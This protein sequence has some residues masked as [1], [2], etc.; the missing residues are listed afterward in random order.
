M[1][2]NIEVEAKFKVNNIKKVID[3]L[4]ASG[5]KLNWVSTIEDYYYT[6]KHRDLWKIGDAL[7]VRIIK[8]KKGGILTYKP[9]GKRVQKIFVHKEHET[10]IENPKQLMRIFSYLDIVPLPGLYVKK[11]R[12]DY[13]CGEFDIVI[14]R[15][16]SVGTFIEIEKMAHSKLE[17]QAA[18]KKIN[19]FSKRLG[20]SDKDRQEVSVV[21]L[22]REAYLKKEKNNKFDSMI[23]NQIK[24]EKV[25]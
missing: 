1:S 14:D 25:L 19:E 10:Y 11:T 17:V 16:P 2:Q 12:Y 22:I 13:T 15:Y 5:A 4:K 8:G 7:R 18:K 24:L 3:R 9:S 23:D 20:F 21:V 6:P